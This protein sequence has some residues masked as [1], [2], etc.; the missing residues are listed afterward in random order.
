MCF[1]LFW[2]LKFFLKNSAQS[3]QLSNAFLFF[4]IIFIFLN[5]FPF[6]YYFFFFL[7]YNIVLVLPYFNMHLPWVY[8]CSPS[9]SPLPP[10]SPY[11]PYWV[12]PVYHP[13]GSCILHQTWTGDS[14][15]IWY[16][17]CF[18]AILPNHAPPPRI[19]KTVL[20]IRVSFAESHTGLLLPS[21]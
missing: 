18:N 5:F 17:T 21:F 6:L 3:L 16:Y 19:Q 20:Y 12:I 15:L 7:L 9:W 13:Q 10:P 4:S 2:K 11:H 1:C 14:F 8:T